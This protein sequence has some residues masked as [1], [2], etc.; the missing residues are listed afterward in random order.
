MAG[1][2]N[3]NMPRH[4]T[5][6]PMPANN[7]INVESA[8]VPMSATARINHAMVAAAPLIPFT[9]ADVRGHAVEL[10][11]DQFGSRWLQLQLSSSD[12][13]REAKQG[14][15]EELL[16]FMRE[17]ACDTFGNYCVQ[18]ILNPQVGTPE[19]QRAVCSSAFEGHV[20]ELSRNTY[21]CRCIQSLVKLFQLGDAVV[22]VEM[23]DRMLRELDGSVLELVVDSNA[24]HVVQQV[25]ERI[26]PLSRVSFVLESFRGSYVGLAKDAYGCRVCQRVLEY[27]DAKYVRPALEEFLA[28]AEELVTDAMGNYVVQHIITTSAVAVP[29]GVYADQV[30][31]LVDVVKRNL[32]VF[33]THKFASNVVEKVLE[34]GDDKTRREI[35]LLTLEPVQVGGGG[36]GGVGGAGG[37]LMIHV[38]FG[39]SFANYVCQR[40]LQYADRDL[41]VRLAVVVKQNAGTLR[42]MTYGKHILAACEKACVRQGVVV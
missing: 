37:V 16:P 22:P 10:A 29:P 17:L 2:G 34:Y 36:G 32:L 31:R 3:G 35:V 8:A 4:R 9:L 25:L 26:R 20:L 7:I 15:F 12:V 27:A 6:P 40:C 38:M 42:R 24:N 30:Q 28:A 33:A 11:K 18:V 5:P 39:D 13:P 1:G 23:Q 19:Q 21:A 41:L 14:L